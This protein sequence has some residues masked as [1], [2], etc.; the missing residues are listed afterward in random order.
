MGSIGRGVF[1]FIKKFTSQNTGSVMKT[2]L[3][4]L[5]ITVECPSQTM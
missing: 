5:M 1:L 4:R 2:F 3:L